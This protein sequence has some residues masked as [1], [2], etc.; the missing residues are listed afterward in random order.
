M[1]LSFVFWAHSGSKMVSPEA[2][3]PRWV[4]S[5]VC[6]ENG[7]IFRTNTKSKFLITPPPPFPWNIRKGRKMSFIADK[8][9]IPTAIDCILHMSKCPGLV[10][11]CVNNETFNEFHGGKTVNIVQLCKSKLKASSLVHN[12]LQLKSSGKCHYN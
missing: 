8:K 5:W 2:A 10:L 11:Q 3:P 4:Q 1:A 9:K 12:I 6:K 7:E